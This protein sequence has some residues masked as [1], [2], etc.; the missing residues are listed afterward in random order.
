MRAGLC[1]PT[2][3][4]SLRRA[5]LSEAARVF[6]SSG[7]SERRSLYSVR[8]DPRSA[9]RALPTPRGASPRGLQHLRLSYTIHCG[10]L[11]LLLPVRARRR[12]GSAGAFPQSVFRR[13][14]EP[15]SGARLQSF[16][17]SQWGLCFRVAASGVPGFNLAKA[18]RTRSPFCFGLDE[19][20]DGHG[21]RFG[22][23]LHIKLVPKG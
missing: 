7:I 2:A 16:H 13:L 1:R 19:L 17:W 6:G 8:W 3:W 5:A 23:L 21:G 4:V 18:A 10:L 12:S 15:V 14:S 9:A 22:S 20:R 11:P